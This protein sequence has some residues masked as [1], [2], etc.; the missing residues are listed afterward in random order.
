MGRSKKSGRRSYQRNSN[1][2]TLP[3][4]VPS[5][6]VSRFDIDPWGD[7]F[8]KSDL[9]GPYA[10]DITAPENR[11]VT[12][13]ARRPRRRHLRLLEDRRQWHP[14][15]ARRAA[16]A[17]NRWAPRVVVPKW[18]AL[19]GAAVTAKLAFTDPSSVA[20]CVRRKIRREVM[21]ARGHSGRRGQRRPKRNWFSTIR[22]RR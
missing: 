21:F 15:G 2:A 12:E 22:C 9:V 4:R 3:T 13:R 11:Y 17:F 16:K 6:R 14:D 1:V 10:L 7:S 8:K 19:G 5:L 20:I 18:A